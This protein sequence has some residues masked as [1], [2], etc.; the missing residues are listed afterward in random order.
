MCGT[1][2]F[3]MA[4]FR[5]VGGWSSDVRTNRARAA[6]SGE[7]ET[8]N[9]SEAG[10]GD[11][12][13]RGTE[14]A[15]GNGGELQGRGFGQAVTGTVDCSSDFREARSEKGFANVS[16]ERDSSDWHVEG[17]SYSRRG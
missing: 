4:S 10:H 7:V 15:R 1:N 17:P 16:S 12:V 5:W 6:N 9:Y 13:A 3:F 2:G 11:V 8:E 14:D